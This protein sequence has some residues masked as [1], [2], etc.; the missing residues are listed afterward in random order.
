[1]TLEFLQEESSLL[2]HLTKKRIN[3]YKETKADRKYVNAAV[4]VL[5]QLMDKQSKF[6]SLELATLSG[7]INENEKII[8]K[9]LDSKSHSRLL[10]L[11]S[12]KNIKKS[13]FN[14]IEE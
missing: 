4:Q 3:L 1:M 5:N 8:E 9:H 11:S 14:K 2:I 6:K 13:I 7:I 12:S 10:Y